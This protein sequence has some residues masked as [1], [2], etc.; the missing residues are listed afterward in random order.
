[1]KKI[2]KSSPCWKRK[3]RANFEQKTQ[4]R[5]KLQISNL[6]FREI[7]FTGRKFVFDDFIFIAH[8]L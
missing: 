5:E 7:L 6:T 3:S 2:E 8:D 4:N 1:M